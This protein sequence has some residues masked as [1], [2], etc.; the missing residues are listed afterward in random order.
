MS[1]N[2]FSDSSQP[3]VFCF[4]LPSY[5]NGARI[6]ERRLDSFI[7]SLYLMDTVYILTLLLSSK[8]K[9]VPLF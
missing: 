7:I 8:V 9:L 1:G 6:G 2:E 3:A 4:N 5:L